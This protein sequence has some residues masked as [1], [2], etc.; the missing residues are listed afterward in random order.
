M[1]SNTIVFIFMFFLLFI[2]IFMMAIMEY[3]KEK[4]D[5][6]TKIKILNSEKFELEHRLK[7][8]SDIIRTLMDW[9]KNID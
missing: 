1:E 8:Q 7:N 3:K 4:W 2:F 5:F 9:R 6:E